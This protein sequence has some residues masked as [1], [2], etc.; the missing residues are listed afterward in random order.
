MIVMVSGLLTPLSL[1]GPAA[2]LSGHCLKPSQKVTVVKVRPC[3]SV[4]LPLDRGGQAAAPGQSLKA[5]LPADPFLF[6]FCCQGPL[7]IGDLPQCPSSL[8]PLALEG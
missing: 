8:A 2:L 4:M 7:L 5:R 1:V 3:S 6:P